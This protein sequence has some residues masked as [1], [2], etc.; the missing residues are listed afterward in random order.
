MVFLATAGWSAGY[1]A[2]VVQMRF[3]QEG[4]PTGWQRQ[5]PPIPRQLADIAGPPLLLEEGYAIHSHAALLGPRG[6]PGLGASVVLPEGSTVELRLGNAAA[7]RLSN[8]G[9]GGA[10]V[11]APGDG[12]QAGTRRTVLACDDELDAA[13]FAGSGTVGVT[14]SLAVDGGAVLATVGEQRA[15]CTASVGEAM[16]SIQAGLRRVGVRSVT[17]TDADF[18]APGSGWPLRLGAGVLGATLLAGAGHLAA[19]RRMLAAFGLAC[20]PLLLVGPLAHADVARFLD[21]ARL[22]LP[23]APGWGLYGPLIASVT[24]AALTTA[25]RLSRPGIAGGLGVIA[26]LGVLAGGAAWALGPRAPAAVAFAAGMG[27]CVGLLAWANATRLRGYNL[28]SLGA[29][30][31]AL[32]LGEHALAR[33]QYGASLVGVSSRAAGRGQA[34]LVGTAFDTFEALENTRA[35]RDYPDRDYPVRPPP[36]S[37]PLRVVALGSSSTAGAYQNDDID[38]FWPADLERALGTGA[39]VI[40]QGVGGWTSLHVR[41][42]MET[43][44][45][46]VDPDILVVYLGHND[47]LTPSPRPYKQLLEAWRAGNDASVATS[48]VLGRLRVYQALRFF[49]QALVATPGDA[50]VPVA[51]ARENYQALADLMDTRGGKLL[52]VRE[53]ISPDPAPLADYGAMMA[54]LGEGEHVSYLDANGVLLDPRAGDAFLDDCH[55]SRGGHVLLAEAVAE[56]LR[57]EGW[58]P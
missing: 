40:N 17:G 39:Q 46:L 1:G 44:V 51:D 45:D 21:G 50:A 41:R 35:F 25:W 55:L 23:A 19:R 26:A 6:A 12:T 47:I 32:F 14:A 22:S 33:T 54:S 34:Q 48:K 53:A 31:L 5:L 57:R 38:Q 28:V 4:V 9:D 30:A 8:V 7:L 18:E 58:L 2:A 20:A 11:L 43:Q 29:V 15:R 16:P 42:Y 52:L 10:A 37:A 27:A 56:S 24:L 36:R 13:L 3:H 49:V